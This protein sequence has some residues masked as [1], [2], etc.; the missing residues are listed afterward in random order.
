MPEIQWEQPL[1]ELTPEE[2]EEFYDVCAFWP[3]GR[4]PAYEADP[5]FSPV[6]TLIVSGEYDP[7]TPPRWG[8]LAADTLPN[9]THVVFPRGGHAVTVETDC[10]RGMV[11]AFFDDP[12][13]PPDTACIAG[14]V[15]PFA[16]SPADLE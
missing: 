11:V 3:A 7:V 9:S 5:V 12:T 8:D 13:A 10:T 16:V 1:A 6:P 2:L 15:L 4:A 14:S